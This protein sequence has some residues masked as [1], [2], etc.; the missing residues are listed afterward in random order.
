MGRSY[1]W[2]RAG[3]NEQRAR[4]CEQVGKGI[5]VVVLGVACLLCG[6]LATASSARAAV[7]WCGSDSQPADRKPDAVASYQFHAMYAVPSD[8]P[9]RFSSV[10]SLITSDLAAI[11]A[12]W[13]MQDP[14]RAVRYDLF[15]FPGCSERMG[16]LDLS[17]VR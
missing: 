10:A 16:R 3:L 14:T 12:W 15:D 11:D 8:R 7:G 2:R 9:D 17:D 5:G 13:Q 6:S 1:A 4:Y